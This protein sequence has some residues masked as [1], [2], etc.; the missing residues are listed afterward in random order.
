[1]ALGVSKP[2][3]NY[4]IFCHQE[5]STWPLEDGKKLKERFDQIFDSDKYNKAEEKIRKYNTTLKG[6][7]RAMKG[8]KNGLKVVLEEANE[9]KKS[10]D[11]HEKRLGTSVDRVAKIMEKISPLTEKIRELCNTENSYM[12]LNADKGIKML[13]FIFNDKF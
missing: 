13:D 10:L 7:L 4:V 2:I 12:K 6:N 3:L 5:D 8:E 1:M 11:Q 9:K